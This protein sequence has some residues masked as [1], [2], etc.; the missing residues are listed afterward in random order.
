MEHLALYPG[1]APPGEKVD[2]LA[3]YRAMVFWSG[4]ACCDRGQ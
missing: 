2:R 3:D 1:I 4:G